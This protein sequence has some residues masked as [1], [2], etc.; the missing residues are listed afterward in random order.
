MDGLSDILVPDKTL[1]IYIAPTDEIFNRVAAQTL[2]DTTAELIAAGIETPNL[3][4]ARG[5]TQ[6][7]IYKLIS[8]NPDMIGVL[9]QAR[10]FPVG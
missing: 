1:R 8:E 4:L 3:T 7:G 5:S 6:T 9:S 10:F 2:C